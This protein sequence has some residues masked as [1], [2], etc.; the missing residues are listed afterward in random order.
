MCGL[1]LESSSKA[2][3]TMV[4]KLKKTSGTIKSRL[5]TQMFS[6]THTHTHTLTTLS[7]GCCWF[8]IEGLK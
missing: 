7:Q 8:L 6:A 1:R 3:R 4:M 2:P 5:H